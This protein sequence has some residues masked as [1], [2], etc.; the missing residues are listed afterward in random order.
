MRRFVGYQPHSRPGSGLLCSPRITGLSDSPRGKSSFWAGER[1]G[2]AHAC[3]EVGFAA[4]N[5]GLAVAREQFRQSILAAGR[6]KERTSAFRPRATR[7]NKTL[8]SLH[9]CSHG[10]EPAPHARARPSN[11]SRSRA[12]WVSNAARL[13]SKRASSN[14]PSLLRRSP[15]TVGNRW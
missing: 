12:L 11:S 4:V 10:V 5:F 15:R 1:T 8:Y 3:G 7:G 6:N 9:G 13:N 14:R 2:R